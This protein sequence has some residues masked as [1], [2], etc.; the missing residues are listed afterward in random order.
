MAEPQVSPDLNQDVAHLTLGILGGTGDQGRGLARR[1]A[2]AGNPVIIGSRSAGRAQ[3]AAAGLGPGLPVSGMADV[4]NPKSGLAY[5][6][7]V[8]RHLVQGKSNKVIAHDLGISPRTV[9]IHRARVLEKL[10]SRNIADLV[11]R[12][13]ATGLLP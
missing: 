5:G 4:V 7:D 9:E 1:F 2:A 11:R 3:E 6:L 8:L 12:T 10:K 13:R